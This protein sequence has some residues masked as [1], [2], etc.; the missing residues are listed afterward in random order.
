MRCITTRLNTATRTRVKKSSDSK[1]LV[2]IILGCT[3]SGKSDVVRTLSKRA[4]IELISADSIQVY[5][6]L[7]IGSAKPD[8]DELS[9]FKHHL[10]DIKNFDETFSVGDFVNSAD[11]LVLD[12]HKRGS[13]PVIS[14]GTF[15]YVKNF[16]YGLPPSPESN[17]DVR[18]EINRKRDRLGLDAL[19]KELSAL[20]PVYASKIS[21][22]DSQRITRG[23]EICLSSGKRVSDFHLNNTIRDKYSYAI[24]SIDME[25][26]IL[27]ERIKA[28]ID[29][30]FAMGL[31]DEV[32]RLKSEGAT[33]DMQSMKGIGYREFFTPEPYDRE[34]VKQNI[35]LDTVHYAKRQATFAR[36]LGSIVQFLT[37]GEIV[38]SAGNLFVLDH[39]NAHSHT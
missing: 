18:D 30:M 34:R 1:P 38:E 27:R 19:Y 37:A 24:Y 35:F 36:S 21:K 29:K 32:A 7:D 33:A 5:K 23:L 15:F 12:I 3:A 6:G 39:L 22:N 28:R 10:V 16:L 13:V 26:D 11:E 8:K 4:N 14:G 25:R 31:E 20:D 17:A 9:E 2:L